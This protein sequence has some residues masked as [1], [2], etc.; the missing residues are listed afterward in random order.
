MR[1]LLFTL[2]LL[3]AA[4]SSSA[5]Y[6][7]SQR[8]DE[9]KEEWYRRMIDFDYNVPDYNVNKPDFPSYRFVRL[10]SLKIS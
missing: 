3:M 10:N 2:V 1:K 7:T 9:T 8:W 5:Q 4:L 6:S